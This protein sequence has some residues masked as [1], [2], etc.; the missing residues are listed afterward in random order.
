MTWLDVMMRV[1]D[2]WFTTSI[3]HYNRLLYYY[4]THTHVLYQSNRGSKIH[5]ETLNL[6]KGG[7]FVN[8]EQQPK[9]EAGQVEHAMDICQEKVCFTTRTPN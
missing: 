1:V 7:F 5:S 4:H 9:A 8:K 6:K 2:R 3:F